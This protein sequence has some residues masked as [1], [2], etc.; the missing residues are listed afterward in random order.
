M[1]IKRILVVDD[2]AT[3]RHVIGELLSK[4]GFEVSFAEDGE[5]GV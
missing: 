1:A 5:T 3:E 4:N 2:S